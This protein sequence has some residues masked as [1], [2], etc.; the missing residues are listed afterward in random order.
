M[1][2]GNFRYYAGGDIEN[3]Q[4]DQIRLLLNNGNNAA[5]R[6][7]AMKASHHGADTATSRGFVNRLRPA[8]AVISCGTRNQYGHPDP[9]TINVLDGYPALPI[10]HAATPPPDMPVANYLTGYQYIAPGAPPLPPPPPIPVSRGG[11]MSSTSGN[12]MV[13]PRTPGHVV[14]NVSAAQS[15]AP[16]QGQVYLAVRAATQAA[17]EAPGLAG[18]L[19]A[20]AAGPMAT[21]TAEVALVHG[22][23]PAASSVITQAGGP[24]GAAA[25]A[26]AAANGPIPVGVAAAM[27]IAVTTAA[28]G[29][30]P[31]AA[32]SVA[33]AAGAA[34]ATYHGGGTNAAAQAAV[35][36]ALGFAGL[37]APAPRP[38]PPPWVLPAPGPGLF[39][40][41]FYDRAV[42]RTGQP[43]AQ[44]NAR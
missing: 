31:P 5:G 15:L 1:T 30:V 4:E 43:P 39:D 21:A 29:V 20:G 27:A 10:P 33:A 6:V 14:V 11:A 34:A 44:M 36:G 25:A 12:P 26:L 17:R 16:V 40:V 7:L 24:A 13:A 38:S 8:A 35:L 22:A 32:P 9:E 2:F 28:L 41:N 37:A 42:P 23:G 18:A 3:N 19:A